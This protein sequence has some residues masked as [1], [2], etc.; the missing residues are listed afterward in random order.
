MTM[1]AMADPK[2][3]APEVASR[4][5]I[6]TTTLYGLCKWLRYYERTGKALISGKCN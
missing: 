2:T 5:S 6:T 3:K 4:L 1:T